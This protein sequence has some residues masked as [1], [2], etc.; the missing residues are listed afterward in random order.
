MTRLGRRDGRGVRCART[1]GSA[2]SVREQ[3]REQQKDESAT[4][5]PPARRTRRRR[6]SRLLDRRTRDRLTVA[7]TCACGRSARHVSDDRTTHPERPPDRAT[8]RRSRRK[9]EKP[10]GRMPTDRG[11]WK[12]RGRK[13]GMN[14]GAGHVRRP[15]A[16]G[17]SARRDLGVLKGTCETSR[18]APGRSGMADRAGRDTD[19]SVVPR[20]ADCFGAARAVA[21]ARRRDAGERATTPR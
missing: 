7:R 16:F 3:L 14:A 10:Q 19:P 20:S 13:A 6:G 18:E 1:D 9:S 12:K 2:A 8:P 15:A 17:A 5:T 4:P 21:D 11:P